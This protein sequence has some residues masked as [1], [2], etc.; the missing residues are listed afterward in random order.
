MFINNEYV[1]T[2]IDV[3]NRLEEDL[4]FLKDLKDRLNRG[5]VD[6]AESAMVEGGL[7][8]IFPELE[9]IFTDIEPFITKQNKR[10]N[11]VLE[12]MRNVM[13]EENIPIISK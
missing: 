1:M 13:K 3:A 5:E 11:S 12:D 6:E 2:E 8:E 4:V 10:Y 7:R 9:K